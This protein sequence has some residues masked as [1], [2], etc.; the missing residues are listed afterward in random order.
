ME[1][2]EHV[3]GRV[4]HVKASELPTEKVQRQDQSVPSGCGVTEGRSIEE[5][6]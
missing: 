5:V 4:K 6:R 1:R 2:S 3:Y